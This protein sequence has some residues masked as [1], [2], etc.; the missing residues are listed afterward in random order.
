M[1]KDM[2]AELE[3]DAKK[4]AEIF[5]KAMCVCETGERDL[6]G[7]IDHSNGEITR[8]TSKIE[9]ETAE[10][11]KL[12]KDL[13]LHAKDKVDTE[14]NLEES[15][16]LREKENAKFVENEKVTMF[17]EDQL[18][19]AIPLFEKK[20]AASFMQTAH[21]Q[22]MTLRK[23]VEVGHYL[24]PEKRR[25]V[26]SFLEQSQSGRANEPSAAAAEIIGMMKA[27][28][29]EMNS[30]LA[31]MRKTETDDTNAFNDM[32]ENKLNHLG[33]L[34]KMLSDKQK[35][36]GELALSISE[37]KDA[38]EDQNTELEDST[39]YLAALMAAC[40]QR[41]KD[42]DM[43]NKMR[44]DEIAA[45]SEAIKILTDDDALEVFKKAVPSASFVQQ[46]PKHALDTWDFLQTSST[47]KALARVHDNAPGDAVK[48]AGQAAKVV[49]FMIDNMV[50]T[51]HEDDVNDEHKKDWCANETTVMHQL[52]SDKK[53]LT[54]ELTKKLEQLDNELATLTEEIKT[55]TMEIEDL[56]A[57]V[58]HATEQRKKEHK[59]FA[60]EYAN[61]ALAK[62]LVKK[63][64]KR[65]EKFYSP[66]AALLSMHQRHPKKAPVSAVVARLS[67]DVDFDS[68]VQ[69][70]S[71]IQVRNADG[72]TVD[73][74]VLPDTPQKYEKSESGG[75]MGLMNNMMSDLES[76]IRE[77]EVEEKHAAKDYVKLMKESAK[78]EKEETRMQTNQKNDLT[79]EEVKHL[80]L[81]LAQL[82]TECDFLMRNFDNR[83]SARVGEEHGLESAESIVTKEK[84]QTHGEIESEFKSEDSMKDVHEH[85]PDQEMPVM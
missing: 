43:R 82:H 38:L 1:L 57:D 66:N 81:Y 44:N 24:N 8:L 18:A 85:Y 32:K 60:T 47:R 10:K 9:S 58:F 59:E 75:V 83:H 45:I 41:R 6:Q 2:S 80:Q 49:D 35:R 37:D 54:E 3:E 7:V 16:A 4:E 21:H 14:K 53:A 31:D 73:P 63:A 5:D 69:V 64:A 15:A 28:Q 26:V 70:S 65:L 50:E 22:G 23:I 51:L 11:E 19:R 12:D 20:G 13:E 34:M 78:A 52:E 76:D 46:P 61:A 62:S 27:M 72:T 17:S 84:V 56:D 71:K 29:D 55:T 40:E 42:R 48:H 30:D 68:F 39:K 67:K 77:G 33:N 36:S 74:I 79:I 25:A